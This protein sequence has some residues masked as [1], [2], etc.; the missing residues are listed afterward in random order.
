MIGIQTGWEFWAA[1]VFGFEARD[2]YSGFYCSAPVRLAD[3][4]ADG[5]WWEFRDQLDWTVSQDDAL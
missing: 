5:T 4:H 3:R 1:L 2:R